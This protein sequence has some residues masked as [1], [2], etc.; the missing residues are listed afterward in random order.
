MENYCLSFILYA[1]YWILNQTTLKLDYKVYH[2]KI[3]IKLINKIAI[4]RK[5]QFK[6]FDD[7]INEIDT[8][9]NNLPL[10]LK[11][12]SKVFASQTKVDCLLV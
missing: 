5:F 12:Q 2:F 10:F 8:T 7:E 1:P 9:F 6:G 3:T 4:I 11:I